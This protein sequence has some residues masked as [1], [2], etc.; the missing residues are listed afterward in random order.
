MKRR[1]VTEPKEKG[2]VKRRVTQTKKI[3]LRISAVIA[4]TVFCALF[5]LWIFCYALLRG[6]SVTARDEFTVY[7]QKSVVT[8][9]IPYLFLESDT[10]REILEE[11]E[12]AK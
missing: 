9:N 5:A 10:V 3:I 6:P 11:G 8:K 12:V 1:I 4:V 7:L 2:I